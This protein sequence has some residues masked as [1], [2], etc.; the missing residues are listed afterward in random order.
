MCFNCDRI[1]NEPIHILECKCQFCKECLDKFIAMATNGDIVINK[2]EKSNFIFIFR[3]NSA[4]FL[5]L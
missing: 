4:S 3:E 1:F 5:L 2:Y